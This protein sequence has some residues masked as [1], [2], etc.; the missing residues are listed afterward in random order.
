MTDEIPA[1]R[2]PH[3]FVVKVND[4]LAAA[5]RIEKRFD[6]GHAHMV[7]LHAFVWQA[8]RHSFAVTERDDAGA[9]QDY[10][11]HLGE[12]VAAMTRESLLHMRGPVP[13]PTAPAEE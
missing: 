11:S 10:A 2:L 4:F 8:A 5:A 1:T 12:L 9:R 13:E 3:E 7:L 6:T